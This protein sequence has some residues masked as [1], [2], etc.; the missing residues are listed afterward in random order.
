MA[1][2]MQVCDMHERLKRFELG[3]GDVEMELHPHHRSLD[4]V[5]VATAN[6]TVS[7]SVKQVTTTPSF[8]LFSL[9]LV[10]TPLM[11]SPHI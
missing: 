2:R 9:P 10:S 3:L 1:V 7:V 8:L 5:E 4:D 11:M 6:Q